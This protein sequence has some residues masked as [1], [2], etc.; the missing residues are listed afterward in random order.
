[1]MSSQKQSLKSMK[2]SMRL[3]STFFLWLITLCLTSA[4][5][6][7]KTS[8]DKPAPKELIG[9]ETNGPFFPSGWKQIGSDGFGRSPYILTTLR[10]DKTYA[11]L[12]ERQLNE[13]KKGERIRA[14]VTDAIGVGNPTSY[15]RF[16]HLCYFPGEEAT[17]T[18]SNILAE[19]GFTKYCDMKTTL[20]RRAWRINLETG[21]FDPLISTKG[22]TCEYGYVSLGEPDFREGCPTYSFR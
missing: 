12:L 20:I 22:L 5:A 18:T 1:M 8:A 17:K 10:R 4:F 15:H 2:T 9:L 13:P 11:M 6:A 21:K 7:D 19:I 14:V 3:Y 16:S